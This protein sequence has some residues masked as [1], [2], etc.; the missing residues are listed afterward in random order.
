MGRSV[1]MSNLLVGMV[2]EQLV[3]VY[4]ETIIAPPWRGLGMNSDI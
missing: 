3:I 1:V 4:L 2:T